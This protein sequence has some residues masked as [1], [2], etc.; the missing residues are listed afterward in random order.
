[1]RRARA[2]KGAA[3]SSRGVLRASRYC[4]Q[5]VCVAGAGLGQAGPGPPRA[6]GPP[7]PRPSIPVGSRASWFY[8]WGHWLVR[9]GPARGRGVE[10]GSAGDS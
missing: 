8:G 10:R 2:T 9:E 4:R 6:G 5:L 7:A 3:W 1:M